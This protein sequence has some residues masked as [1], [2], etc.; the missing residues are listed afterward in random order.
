[1][2][3]SN[4]HLRHIVHDLYR[5]RLYPVR[6][7]AVGG[8]DIHVSFS[9]IA[10]PSG[11]PPHPKRPVCF[12]RSGDP[13]RAARRICNVIHDLNGFGYGVR[14]PVAEL[15]GVVAAPHPKGPVC[16]DNAVCASGGKCRTHAAHHFRGRVLVFAASFAKGTSVE[17]GSPH[18]ERSVAR[19]G[20]F[21]M[22]PQRS[23]IGA[24]GDHVVQDLLRCA[25]GTDPAPGQ[26]RTL[27]IQRTVHHDH[28]PA[29]H[30]S[31]CR[32]CDTVHFPSRNHVRVADVAAPVPKTSV[33]FDRSNNIPAAA[34]GRNVI[35]DFRRHGLD[36]GRTQ[37]CQLLRGHPI[38]IKRD[39]HI[40]FSAVAQ[41]ASVIVAP[42]PKGTI[43]QNRC[44]CAVSCGDRGGH[45][46]IYVDRA[47]RVR[48]GRHAACQRQGQPDRK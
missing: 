8:T 18:P 46:C 10:Q 45:V 40:P 38:R 30:R 16:F 19:H 9:A 2:P 26:I 7:G 37:I 47:E 36:P 41:Q 32:R 14:R 15:A 23:V 20:K 4:A 39:V 25:D 17:F 24:E 12:D 28:L 1:M 33:F 3:F 22:V 35:H 27:P 31:I 34:D 48:R 5:D 29:A 13:H 43:L 6:F 21:A 44:A 42:H 11:Q